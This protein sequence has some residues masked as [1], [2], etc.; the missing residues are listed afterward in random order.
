MSRGR[1]LG[2]FWLLVCGRRESSQEGTEQGQ[3]VTG[4]S[5]GFHLNAFEQMDRVVATGRYRRG[6]TGQQSGGTHTKAL[7]PR[8]VGAKLSPPQPIFCRRAHKEGQGGRTGRK[9]EGHNKG[10][11]GCPASG[12]WGQDGVWPSPHPRAEWGRRGGQEG[13]GAGEDDT[14]LKGRGGGGRRLRLEKEN[15]GHPLIS[16]A[17]RRGFSAGEGHRSRSWVGRVRGWDQ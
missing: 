12:R 13:G 2:H 5:S 6:Q 4:I 16:P 3:G 9:G 17:W 10:G 8:Q 1:D 15:R 11:E 7:P 14:G